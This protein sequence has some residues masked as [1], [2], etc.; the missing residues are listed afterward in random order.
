MS[1]RHGLRSSA[2]LVILL[3]AIFI[4][5]CGNSASNQPL[6][7]A[8]PSAPSPAAPQSAA[9][10][11]KAK[12]NLNTAS[13]SDL[14][15]IPTMT[16]RM[17][18]EFEEYRPYQSIQQFRKEMGKYVSSA[19]IADYEKY[20]YVPISENDSDAPTLQQIPGL[21]ASEATALIA[22]RPYASRDAFV[23]KLAEKVSPDEL[24][25]AKTYLK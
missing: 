10:A 18:H 13:S 14:L 16:T 19:V 23:S 15:T 8:A 7:S 6:N 12:L 1:H 21:D 5:G 25:I 9:A 22:G 17:V 20:V 3:F 24:V 2:P 4:F 11:P